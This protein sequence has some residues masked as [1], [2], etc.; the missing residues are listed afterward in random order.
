MIT[1]ID[2]S[3]CIAMA[4]GIYSVVRGGSRVRR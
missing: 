1:L 4:L 2:V 3:T